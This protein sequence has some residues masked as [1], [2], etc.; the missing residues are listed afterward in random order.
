MTTVVVA[1]A[2]QYRASATVDCTVSSFGSW[3]LALCGEHR[4]A[5]D[6][7]ATS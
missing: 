5:V 6:L 7:I 4:A 3:Q 1:T 2:R